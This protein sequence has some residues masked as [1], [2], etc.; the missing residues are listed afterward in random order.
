MKFLVI[1]DHNHY[2]KNPPDQSHYKRLAD[3]VMRYTKMDFNGVIYMTTFIMEECVEGLAKFY[4][5][6]HVKQIASPTLK[7]FDELGEWVNSLKNDIDYRNSVVEERG[8]ALE[9]AKR[10]R[11]W[12]GAKY[13]S[14]L[15]A[16]HFF[17]GVVI[18]AGAAI[19]VPLVVPT[20]SL[21]EAIQT[22]YTDAVN[23]NETEISYIQVDRQR[24]ESLIN[25]A[26]TELK[27]ATA[28]F[29]ELRKAV[30]DIG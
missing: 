30:E 5:N 13:W 9:R 16:L 28:S 3:E 4:A 1:N 8:A 14:Q 6:N 21:H 29:D 20:Y 23:E 10:N 12:L 27:E 7:N 24:E 26:I 22:E 19:G 17:Q 18:G 11:T 25:Q 15:I 2:R